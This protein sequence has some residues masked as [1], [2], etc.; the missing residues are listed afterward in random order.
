ME[1]G[2][3]VFRL[4]LVC[5]GV[6][7]LF[8]SGRFAFGSSLEVSA[9]QE[10]K[11]REA[12]PEIPGLE[13]IRLPQRAPQVIV[14]SREVSVGIMDTVL[15]KARTYKVFEDFKELSDARRK[16]GIIASMAYLCGEGLTSFFE[17][18]LRSSNGKA[19]LKYCIELAYDRGP[20]LLPFDGLVHPKWSVSTSSP[21]LNSAFAYVESEWQNLVRGS[22]IHS[23]GSLLVTPDPVLVPAG[24]FQEIYYW[25]T[26]FGVKGLQATE[27]F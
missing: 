3:S 26:Y 11:K 14:P 4:F 27:R 23:D 13:V 8:S 2:M 25:D 21:D 1:I 12:Y 24:R 19:M 7:S 16:T 9:I 17:S 22:P 5:L 10:K 6:L 20:E 18:F 15:E